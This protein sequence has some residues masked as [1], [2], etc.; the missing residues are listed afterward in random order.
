MLKY[1]IKRFVVFS[2]KYEYFVKVGTFLRLENIL[3]TT[4]NIKRRNSMSFKVLLQ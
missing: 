4:D 2:S 1:K 3:S